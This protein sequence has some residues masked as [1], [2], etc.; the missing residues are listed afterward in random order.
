MNASLWK[1]GNCT[2]LLTKFSRCRVV[3]RLRD[4]TD[5]ISSHL[6]VAAANLRS[7]MQSQINRIRETI[8]RILNE[9]TTLAERVRTL[10]REQGTAIGSILTALGDNDDD[11][12]WW[13]TPHLCTWE[14]KTA[15]RP[16]NVMKH[17]QR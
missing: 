1:S 8:S 12:D 2:K 4:L 17:S 6:E 11:D 15:E 5:E 7:A 13:F 10:F 3:E 16:P 9:D 14:N